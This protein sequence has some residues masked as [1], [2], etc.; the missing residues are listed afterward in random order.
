MSRPSQFILLGSLLAASIACQSASAAPIGMPAGSTVWMEF[1]TT[2]DYAGS[3]QAGLAPPNGIPLTTIPSPIAALGRGTVYA[4]IL[5]TSIRTFVDAYQASAFLH[6][7][8]QDTYTVSGAA[9]GPFDITVQ[10]HVDGLMS[11]LTLFGQT[12][13]IAFVDAKIGTFNPSSDP[14]FPEGSR[15]SPFDAGAHA[16]TGLVQVF[17][18][19]SA[20]SFPVDI[21]ASYTKTGVNV[22]DVFD[23]GYQVRSTASSGQID[24]RNTGTISFD[25]P[26]GVFLTSALAESLVPEP[27]GLAL[28]AAAGLSLAAVWLMRRGLRPTQG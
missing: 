12:H 13:L 18:P 25:L 10:L 11:G 24:L 27:S 1:A 4:E 5:P 17:Y 16:S 6:A 28:L 22:G 2:A 21:T 15:V 23:I 3:N 9:A 19:A 26:D 8:F 20:G 14:D 7:S